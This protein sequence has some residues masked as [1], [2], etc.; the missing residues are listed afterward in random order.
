M[1]R[2]SAYRGGGTKR[3][4]DREWFARNVDHC[5]NPECGVLLD[6]QNMHLPNS[7]VVD[8]IL[9]VARA[10]EIGY[11]AEQLLSRE[12]QQALCHRCNRAKSDKLPGETRERN[13]AGGYMHR[14]QVRDGRC[15]CGEYG[16][17]HHTDGSF[18]DRTPDAPVAFVT[19][20]NWAR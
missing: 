16:P 15:V 14:G 2:S 6:W 10:D 13:R 11:S 8:H 1:G 4:R 19:G 5:Q 12:N 18:H 17:H 9:P 3:K 20:R 7:G